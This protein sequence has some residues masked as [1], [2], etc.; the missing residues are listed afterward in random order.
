VPQPTAPPR[1]PSAKR[2]IFFHIE[3]NRSKVTRRIP[4]PPPVLRLS[5]VDISS[6]I[7]NFNIPR[8]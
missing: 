5:P 1:G 3:E 4:P 8:T 7:L 2:F 6:Q